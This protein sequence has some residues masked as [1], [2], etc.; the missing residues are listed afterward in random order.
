MSTAKPNIHGAKVMLCI[1]WGHL[2]VVYLLWA[3]ETEWNHHRE[4]IS[5]V[6]DAFEPRILEET[7]TVP[8]EIH[9]SYPPA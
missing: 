5:N 1:W 2:G 8:R 3:V 6:I 9:Q 4:S 7:T